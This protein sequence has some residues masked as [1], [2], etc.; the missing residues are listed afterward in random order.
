MAFRNEEKTMS[1]EQNFLIRYALHNFVTCALTSGKRV[2]YI[3]CKEGRTMIRHATS[4]IKGSFGE[5]VEI[6][7]V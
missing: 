1:T 4:L 3:K 5:A 7:L 2:F 6:K